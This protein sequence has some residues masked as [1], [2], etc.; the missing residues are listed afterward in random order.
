MVTHLNQDA[1]AQAEIGQGSCLCGGIRYRLHGALPDFEAC[2][3]RH[4]QKAQGGPFVVVAA[5]EEPAL[6]WL[7]GEDLLTAYRAS[8]GK[9]RVFCRRCG[10][11]IFSRREDAP[12]RIRL[13]VGTLDGA[14]GA[15][16]A[17][18]AHVASKADWFAIDD[19]R[20]QHAGSRPS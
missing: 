11:P 5:I 9:E 7:A 2:H 13:R 16:I 18:H 19:D 3:C 8:P 4:C 6:Q 10:S 20:P 17:S 1:A 12:G 15:S 14:T